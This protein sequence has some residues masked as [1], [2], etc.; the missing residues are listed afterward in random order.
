MLETV[1]AVLANDVQRIEFGGIKFAEDVKI[2]WADSLKVLTMIEADGYIDLLFRQD[3]E[4]NATL[5][6]IS[7]PVFINAALNTLAEI[8]EPFV[9]INGW[10][11]FLSGP[12]L[13]MAEGAAGASEATALLD[14]MNWKY[15]K[16]ADVA[17]FIAP[18]IIS[19]IINEAYLALEDGVSTKASIDIAMKLGTGYPYGPFEWCKK[20]GAGKVLSLLS[21]LEREDE[22]YR[23]APLL[24]SE[25]I[26]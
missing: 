4:R 25:T 11:G 9:R 7:K 17:G 12:V 6:K 3:V 24:I 26:S 16:V 20:I 14:K 15:K 13:E 21:L 23:P 2:Q 18:R 1:I 8:G 22:R 10:P 5:R 19:L